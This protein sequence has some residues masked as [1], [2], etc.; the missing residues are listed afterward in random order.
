V[1]D[2]TKYVL[3]LTER[4]AQLVFLLAQEEFL[5]A[6]DMSDSEKDSLAIMHALEC[7]AGLIPGD[8]L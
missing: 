4:E 3:E 1:S 2:R 7:Q 6:S 8:P 5:A